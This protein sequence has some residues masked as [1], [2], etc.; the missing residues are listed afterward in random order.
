MLPSYI[1]YSRHCAAGRP[2][3]PA[4]PQ[5]DRPEGC[6]WP[7]AHDDPSCSE[8]AAGAKCTDVDAGGGLKLHEAA[9]M[10]NINS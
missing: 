4:P 1:G 3:W 2:S 8:P 7:C 6:T 5:E 9:N 10:K